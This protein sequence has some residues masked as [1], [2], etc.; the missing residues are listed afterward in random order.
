MD[1][2]AETSNPTT[3]GELHHKV[4][5]PEP[6][7]PMNIQPQGEQ[8]NDDDDDNDDNVERQDATTMGSRPS[9][10]A[11]SPNE[12]EGG[13]VFEEEEASPVTLKLSQ[14]TPYKHEAEM[15]LEKVQ[16]Q[17][18]LEQQQ[19]WAS[20][21]AQNGRA[22][23]DH[24]E[25]DDDQ[26]DQGNTDNKNNIAGGGGPVGRVFRNSLARASAYLMSLHRHELDDN[27]DHDDPPITDDAT[28]IFQDDEQNESIE[29]AQTPSVDRIYKTAAILKS[30]ATLRFGPRGKQQ[31]KQQQEQQQQRPSSRKLKITNR[32]ENDDPKNRTTNEG[33]MMKVP[34]EEVEAG[35]AM[36][37]NDNNNKPD[38]ETNQDKSIPVENASFGDP[39]TTS[40]TTTPMSTRSNIDANPLPSILRPQGSTNSSHHESLHK[41][42]LPFALRRS[43][44]DV[45]NVSQEEWN[46]LRDFFRPKKR[47]IFQH[48]FLAMSLILMPCLAI[49]ILLFYF[50]GN[51][52]VRFLFSKREGLFSVRRSVSA[53]RTLLC[54]GSALF[55]FL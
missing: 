44:I 6:V 30:A 35:T 34:E 5:S 1:A 43:W 46:S 18:L 32:T 9:T 16:Q 26:H 22:S 23:S 19:K 7:G 40:L 41:R 25:E 12:E 37:S 14:A 47:K 10:A 52:P 11:T 48:A 27:H 51:P 49:A 31:H 13:G 24:Q 17:M 28:G 21:A 2:V 45:K 38:D 15:L 4:S 8:D 39:N 20:D 29:L 53:L 36:T 54:H 42:T 55:F 33:G 50:M 3:S